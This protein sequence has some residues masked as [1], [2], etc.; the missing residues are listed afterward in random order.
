LL[1]D[2]LAGSHESWKKKKEGG[3]WAGQAFV[4]RDHQLAGTDDS[5]ENVFPAG[6]ER[7]QVK[8]LPYPTDNNPTS[9]ID[10]NRKSILM[11]IRNG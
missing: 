10:K 11:K 1:R 2:S 9:N 6:K 5:W 8:A 7:K 4:W 3:R